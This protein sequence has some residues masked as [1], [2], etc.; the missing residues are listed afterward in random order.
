MTISNEALTAA[1]NSYNAFR[2]HPRVKEHDVIG[3][4]DFTQHSSEERFYLVDIQHNL[5][6][7]RQALVAHGAGSDPTGSGYA[8]I[9]SNENNSHCSSGGAIATGAI[10]YGQHGRSTR[11]HGLEPGV[12]DNMFSRVMVIHPSNY[13]TP[14][15]VQQMGRAGM[16]WGCLAMG[17]QDC[18]DYND[19]L[20][21]GS[22]IYCYT[23]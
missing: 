12:N 18:Q 16:S 7:I 9:F 22:F 23:G 19:L 6:V 10:Y 13:V 2:L 15:Y 14:A 5:Q 11:L 4:V 17:P 21:G 3:V 8:T 1:I 20:Q